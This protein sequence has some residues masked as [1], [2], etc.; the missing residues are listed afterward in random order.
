MQGVRLTA[1]DLWMPAFLF[2]SYSI[3]I[4]AYFCCSRRTRRTCCDQAAN[5]RRNVIVQ[6]GTQVE[7]CAAQCFAELEREVGPV[8]HDVS[9]HFDELEGV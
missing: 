5:D 2:G 6:E 1:S 3:E 4:N 8:A 7:R 9:E